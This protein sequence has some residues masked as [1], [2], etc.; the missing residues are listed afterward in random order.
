[1]KNNRGSSFAG[2]WSTIRGTQNIQ[3]L[4][5]AARTTSAQS[6]AIDVGDYIEGLLL[7]NITAASGT[8]P[9]MTLKVQAY[10]DANAVWYDLPDSIAAQTAVGKVL[11]R[12]A[13]FGE[14]IRLDYAITGTTPSFTFSAQ[15]VAK[16]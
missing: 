4:P 15:F 11:V 10:D 13:N 14:Q 2:V 6:G 8:T 5:S 7:I 9:S 16:S 3:V 1:M 12:L